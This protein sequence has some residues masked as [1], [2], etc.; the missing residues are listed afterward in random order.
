[1]RRGGDDSGWA[2]GYKDGDARHRAVGK[3]LEGGVMTHLMASRPQRTSNLVRRG[4]EEHQCSAP[5]STST[6]NF[7]PSAETQQG[8]SVSLFAQVL[9]PA[10][11]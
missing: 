4:F 2:K 5:I 1:M 11:C 3:A 8:M 9:V 6:S 7:S 10:P